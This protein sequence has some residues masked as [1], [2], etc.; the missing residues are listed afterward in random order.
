MVK[1]PPADARDTGSS[2]VLGR[3]H[4]PQSDKARA[5]QLWSLFSGTCEPQIVSL[6][7]Q[8]LKPIPSGPCSA[9]RDDT[10]V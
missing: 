8:L 4:M 5:L 2:P 10:T 3:S 6:V 7:L 1:N 9:T